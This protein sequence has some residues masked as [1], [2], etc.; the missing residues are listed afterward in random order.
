MIKNITSNK[1]R[2]DR[3]EPTATT[4]MDMVYANG[5]VQARLFSEEDA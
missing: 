1:W 5:G 2:G 4:I 3:D